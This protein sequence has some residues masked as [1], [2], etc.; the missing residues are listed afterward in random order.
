MQLV[1]ASGIDISSRVSN[2]STGAM[3]N[4]SHAALISATKIVNSVRY[5]IS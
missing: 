3:Q 5:Y 1:L 2:A 4:I